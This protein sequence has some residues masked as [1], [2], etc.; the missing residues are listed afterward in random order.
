[1]NVVI[2]IAIAAVLTIG[3]IALGLKLFTSSVEEQ[4]EQKGWE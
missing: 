4:E 2:G 3:A 1:M